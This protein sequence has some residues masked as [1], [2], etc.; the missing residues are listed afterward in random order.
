MKNDF[1]SR[2]KRRLRSTVLFASVTLGGLLIL[3]QTAHAWKT[4][5]DPVNY[6]QN[7]LTAVRSLTAINRQVDQLRNEARM[8][9]KMD[10]DL[11]A[12][13]ST[14]SPDLAR[15]L[16]Q[17]KGLMD[18][19]NAIHM[20]VEET[21]REMERLF[22]EEFSSTLDGDE[23]MR[24]ARTRWEQALS[25][26]KRSAN[27]QAMVNENVSEDSTLLDTLLDRSRTA[28]G[29]L[30]A[31]QAGNELAGLGIKQSL[32]LQQMMAAQ[33][34]AE[35]M[36]RA[37]RLAAEEQARVRFGSFMGSRSGAYSASR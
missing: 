15:T 26:Y 16:S 22:P 29:N 9:I 34:R 1:N 36:E 7:I 2:F 14:V 13:G 8:L 37:R 4:V 24:N 25:A 35:T 30:Q 32:Q 19:G 28:V 18:Q 12:L 33:Y 17:L 23:I 3:Q 10:T 21:T 31:S 6:R 11:T 5:F 20:A 27:L